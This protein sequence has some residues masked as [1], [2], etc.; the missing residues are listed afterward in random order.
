M[1]G[2]IFDMDG[3]LF[4]SEAL[5]IICIREGGWLQG[6]EIGEDVIRSTLGETAA[7]SKPLYARLYPGIDPDRLFEDFGKGMRVRAEEKRIPLKKGARELL[8]RLRERG[9]PCAVASSS[10]E[11]YVRLYLES[12]TVTPYFKVIVGAPKGIRSKPQ[13]DIFLLAAEKLGVPAEE[14]MVLEDSENG[15][16]AGRASG[17]FTVMVPDLIPYREAFAPFVDAVVPDLLAVR[18]RWFA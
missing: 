12:Q 14:C 11:E 6:Y 13:P 17:A 9:I 18:E 7:V 10:P 16:R 5:G 4:D 3:L 15:I 8:E 2:V 1:R